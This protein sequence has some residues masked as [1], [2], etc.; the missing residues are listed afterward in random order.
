MT[1][2]AQV[3]FGESLE[4][5]CALRKEPFGPRGP[6]HVATY[7]GRPL[8]SMAHHYIG[9]LMK[10]MAESFQMNQD[11]FTR[12]NREHQLKALKL[13]PENWRAF[14]YLAYNYAESSQ[15]NIH[16]AVVYQAL[17]HELCSNY[18]YMSFLVA[19]DGILS[20]HLDKYL[21][22]A[23]QSDESMELVL[24]AIWD[25]DNPKHQARSMAYLT[26]RYPQLRFLIETS[27]AELNQER[28]QVLADA[29]EVLLARQKCGQ[30]PFSQAQGLRNVASPT[31]TYSEEKE[32]A[33][34]VH[35]LQKI[36][37]QLKS[38]PRTAEYDGWVSMFCARLYADRYLSSTASDEKDVWLNK[39]KSLSQSSISNYQGDTDSSAYFAALLPSLYLHHIQGE[40]PGAS[41]HIRGLVTPWLV[42]QIESL[43]EPWREPQRRA[44]QS[45]A[46]ALVRV[47]SIVDTEAAT[48]FY[49]A[50]LGYAA[51][52]CG[53]IDEAE[54]APEAGSVRFDMYGLMPFCDGK[55]DS[56][57]PDVTSCNELWRC[58]LCADRDWCDSCL[59]TTRQQGDGK[60]CLASH[61][62]RQIWPVP[63][64]AFEEAVTC[65]RGAIWIRRGWWEQ[66]R[67]KWKA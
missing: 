54:I 28:A 60:L 59:I 52:C 18:P 38:S 39:L 4:P 27:S 40:D 25:L 42:S 50:L 55:K 47:L 14:E 49:A 24:G 8:D 7:S 45:S 51:L 29:I 31:G 19:E 46:L 67:V 6:E 66:F 36:S 35:V 16:K 1:N 56:C 13:D 57:S 21:M 10:F 5:G 12:L 44:R 61:T 2:K 22:E 32:Q 63:R 58:D 20:L 53:H 41:P 34:F 23:R 26:H 62:S 9:T 43:E 33:A 17:A 65:Y 30:D 64:E 48:I 37:A 15:R 3:E 11:M